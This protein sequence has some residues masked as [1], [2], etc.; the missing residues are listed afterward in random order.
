[1]RTAV[2]ASPHPIFYTSSAGCNIMLGAI[3][4]I[5]SV[6]F[7]LPYLFTLKLKLVIYKM[8]STVAPDWK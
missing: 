7:K 5:G 4:G 1:M 6:F 2:E 8:S 3:D